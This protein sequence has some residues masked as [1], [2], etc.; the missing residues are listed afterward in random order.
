MKFTTR[1]WGEIEDIYCRIID[2]PFNQELMKGTLDHEKFLFYVQQDSLYLLDYSKVLAII[3][4]KS[5]GT[6]R[7]RQFLQFADYSIAV[8]GWMHKK[9]LEKYSIWPDY[10]KSPVCFSYTN[11]LLSVSALRKIE[12]AMASIL[13]CFWIYAELGDYIYSNA[14]K[15]NPYKDWINAY[16]GGEFKDATEK[17]LKITDE[18]ADSANDITKAQMKEMFILSTKLEFMFWDSAYKMEQWVL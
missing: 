2:L 5:D 7:I 12:E 3:A 15:N 10:Q 16:A 14:S 17:A 4:A 1:L 18:L 8:E 6:E 11:F 13:P 9:I